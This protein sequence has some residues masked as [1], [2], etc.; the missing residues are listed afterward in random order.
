MPCRAIHGGSLRDRVSADAVNAEVIFLKGDSFPIPTLLSLRKMRRAGARSEPEGRG[1][2]TDQLTGNLGRPPAHNCG[3]A[4][5]ALDVF[6]RL[7][8]ESDIVLI[9]L[10]GG[11]ND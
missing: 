11:E 6:D 4:D 7:S 3:P 1:I 2:K 5:L 8:E 10:G 9:E